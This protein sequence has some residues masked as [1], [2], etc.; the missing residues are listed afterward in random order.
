MAQTVIQRASYSFCVLSLSLVIG[1]TGCSKSGTPAEIAATSIVE[2][3]V[4]ARGG[5]EKWRSVQSISMSGKMDAGRVRDPAKLTTGVRKSRVELALDAQRGLLARGKDDADAGKIV[6]LPF[7]MS[8]KRPHKLR[9]EVQFDGQTA[10]QVFDGTN[11]WKLRPF[12]GRDEVEPYTPAEQESASEQQDLD[13]PLVDYAAKGTKVD[14]EGTEPVEGRD[15]YKLKL[16]LKDGQ[17][18]HVWIDKETSL[19]V[20]MDGSRSVNGKERSVATYFRDYRAVDGLMIPHVLET[21]VDGVTDSKKMTIEHVA[22]NPKLE[23]SRFARP[24]ST[25]Q[26]PTS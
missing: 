10:V 23:D 17:V 3:N 9:L 4:A 20:K 22:L 6:E 11:G 24:Y 25:Q 5:L 21:R 1:I 15:A 12:L 26:A 18:R 19:E 16:T 8:M 13:G 14:L 2:K 7:V